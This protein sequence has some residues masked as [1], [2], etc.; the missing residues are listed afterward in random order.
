[1]WKMDCKRLGI[2]RP[3]GFGPHKIRHTGI[4]IMETRTDN[5]TAAISQMVDHKS[6]AVHDIYTHQEVKA[7]Q[8]IQ[9]PMETLYAS[10]ESGNEDDKEQQMYEMYLYLK[11]KFESEPGNKDSDQ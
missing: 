9:T 7:V 10:K 3:K 8:K 4:T 11:R 5:N 1:M 6:Q 2:E